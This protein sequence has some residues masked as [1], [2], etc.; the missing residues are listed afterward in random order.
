MKFK[1]IKYALSIG[2]M[3]C[4]VGIMTVK[5]SS[6]IVTFSV[7]MSTNVLLGTFV[8]GTDTVSARG[9]FNAYGTMALVQDSSQLP[10]YVYTNTVN[11]TADTNGGELQYKFFDSNPS[12][13]GWENPATGQNRA[14]L[15]PLTSGA[16]LVLPGLQ[17]ITRSTF[18]LMLP[19]KSTLAIS[20]RGRVPWKS[21]VCSTAGP[22]VRLR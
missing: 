4:A 1:S 18:K 19:N 11:D 21:G 8:P 7:D 15:L 13:T 6:T 3:F 20:F 10:N 5:A 9:T 12:S 14:A 22:V 2:L 17:L 16:S